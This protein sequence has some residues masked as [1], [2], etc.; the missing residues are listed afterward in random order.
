MN[1]NHFTIII[2]AYNVEQWI[3]KSLESAITQKYD[4][5]DVIFIDA[6]STDNT[7]KIVSSYKDKYNNLFIYQNKVRQ[8][9]IANIKWG[10][11]LS[12]DNTICITLDGDDWLK[13][14]NVLNILNEYYTEDIWMT[15]G[16]YEEFP[17]RNVSMYYHQYPDVIIKNNDFRKY[18]W[19]A[20]HLRTYRKELFLKIKNEDFLD[21]NGEY[22]SMTGDMVMQFPMLEMSGEHSKYISNILYVYNK[23]NPNSDS[24]TNIK[25][26]QDVEIYLRNKIKYKKLEKIK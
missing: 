26:Q 17:Y 9:Q 21:Q 5:F 19:L 13:D 10:T 2:T 16:T 12:Q 4:N 1:K 11:E 20:S 15:Y 6:K 7:F 25:Q 14:D 8:Y 24:E 3:S 18:N 23:T 22:F